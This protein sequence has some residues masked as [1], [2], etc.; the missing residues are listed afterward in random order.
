MYNMKNIL[1]LFGASLLISFAAQAQLTEAINLP[2]IT[3]AQ[4][5]PSGNQLAYPVL[6]LNSSARLE[7]HFDDLDGNVKNY[8]YTY[9]LCNADWTPALLSPFDFIK[10]FTQQ[11]INT[12]RISSVAFTRY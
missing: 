11:R 8:S 2:N 6:D 4:L 12:Y 1:I 5:F 7:L 9:Q 3:T 10:G